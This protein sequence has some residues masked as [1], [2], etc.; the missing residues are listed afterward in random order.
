[1]AN[2]FAATAVQAF[3]WAQINWPWILLY[4]LA[5]AGA[6]WLVGTPLTQSLDEFF[7]QRPAAAELYP[8]LRL[9][10]LREWLR[11]PDFSTAWDT[12]TSLA[13]GVGFLLWLFHLLVSSG[14]LVMMGLRG[15]RRHPVGTG[16]L[17][18][19]RTLARQIQAWPLWFLTWIGVAVGGFLLWR[20]LLNLLVR[21]HRDG[22]VV[23]T[24]YGG[25][26]VAVVGLWV[27]GFHWDLTRVLTMQTVR[28]PGLSAWRAVRTALRR[29][30]AAAG[31]VFVYA[32]VPLGA[33][34]VLAFV[35]K[36]W[37]DLHPATAAAFGWLTFAVGLWVRLW[38]RLA[39]YAHLSCVFTDASA[40]VEA[41][42]PVPAGAVPGTSLEASTD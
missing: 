42:R 32:L 38:N 11:Q 19:T 4:W 37:M 25:L 21:T 6:A 8:G 12:F 10:Y 31:L 18:G 9:L 23:P 20:G 13:M 29:W 30:D 1:M 27:A 2:T 7:R 14:W 15:F 3:R 39:Y 24:W 36:A 40:L 17:L 33:V 16:I 26:A 28:K 35:H 5:V 41:I 22:W 34:S